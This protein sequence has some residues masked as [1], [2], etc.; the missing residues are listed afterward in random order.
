MKKVLVIVLVFLLA[1][2]VSLPGSVNAE[3]EMA[4]E[5]IPNTMN[6]IIV[7]LT[8]D[9]PGYIF[10][11]AFLSFIGIGIASPMTSLGA[12]ASAGQMKFLFYPYQLLFPSLFIALIMLAFTLMGDGLRDALDPRL[13]Q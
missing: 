9:I 4:E 6:V 3:M 2:A 8:F 11:E 13:R 10:A 12:L 1:L 5:Q 7:A